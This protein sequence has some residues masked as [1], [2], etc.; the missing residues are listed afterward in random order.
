M[1]LFANNC[2]D[3]EMARMIKRGL[4]DDVIDQVCKEEIKENKKEEILKPK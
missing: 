3:L 4:S 2:S 1:T